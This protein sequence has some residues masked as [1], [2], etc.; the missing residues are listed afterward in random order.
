M[1]YFDCESCQW[2]SLCFGQ[3][4]V[5]EEMV[6]EVLLVETQLVV[7]IAKKRLFGT[8]EANKKIGQKSCEHW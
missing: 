5:E 1:G 7:L 4:F 8:R 2:Q 6:E 3:L